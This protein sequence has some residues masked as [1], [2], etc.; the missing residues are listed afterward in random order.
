MDTFNGRT[1]RWLVAS[2][3]TVVVMVSLTA[4]APS[5]AQTQ[6]QAPTPTSTPVP[7]PAPTSSAAPL[8]PAPTP[9]ATARPSAGA[10][11]GDPSLAEMNAAHDHSMGSTIAANDPTP[12]SSGAR[13]FAA[14]SG[15]PPGIPGL[16]VSGWQVLTRSDWNTIAANGA[17]FAY[18]KATESTDYQS[19]QF[20][21]QYNDSYA[22]GLM[23]GAYHFA[24]PNTSSGA[25]QAN[26]F[27][28][29]G[30][31][32]SNDGRT[33]PPLL[34]IEYQPTG[35]VCWG[36]TAS[37][38]VSW[39]RDFSNTVLARVGRLPAIYS[40]TDWWTRCTGNNPGFGANPLFIARY[41][42]N[43][44]SGAGTL[45]AGW[46]NYTI[47]QYGSTGLF[48]G[49]QDTFN[50]TA[51][52][53]VA[54]ASNGPTVQPLT[55]PIIGVGDFNGDGRPDFIARRSDGSL[56]F[57]AGTGSATGTANPGYAPAV[58]IG[59]GW[60]I[61]NA[62]V[63]AGDLDGDG[64]PDLIAR[65]PDGTVYAY[66]G[67]GKAGISGNEGYNPA[68][69]IA[70]GWTAYTDL[71]AVGDFNGDG[72][73]DLLGRKSDGSLWLIPGTGQISNGGTF[74]TPTQIGSNWSIF[75]TLIGIGD[76]NKDGK[77]DLIGIGTDNTATFYAG[78]GTAGYYQPGQPIPISG[79]SSTDV[80]ASPGDLDGDGLPDILD[81]T[82]D[83]TLMLMS[84][85]GIRTPGYAPAQNAGGL[86]TQI[87]DMIVPGD[88]NGDGKPDAL[89]EAADG[90]LWLRSGTGTANPAFT[91]A[92]KIGWGWNIFSYLVSAGDING[93][94]KP[95]IL[96]VK[97]DGTLWFY[98]GTGAVSGTD[99]GYRPGIQIGWGWNVYTR[100]VGAGDLDGDGKSDLLAYKSDGSAYF[101]GGTGIVDATHQGYRPAVPLTSNLGA[102]SDLIAP[103][104][105]TGDSK[106]DLIV[107]RPDGGLW[108]YPGTGSV[109]PAGIAFGAPYRI[110]TNWSVFQRLISL[111]DADGDGKTDLMGVTASGTASFYKGTGN[112]GIL[113]PGFAAPIV[114][115]SNW[116]IYR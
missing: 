4:G 12:A 35:D 32:W 56:W 58:Q 75:R 89:T 10:V 50:G 39:I 93:D 87:S 115:G 101:Y 60:G 5:F 11:A 105:F 83:G 18:V 63:G 72:K 111:G 109:T 23:H 31:G 107:R 103:R 38:M 68:V 116:G 54:F 104:D 78:T 2:T 88:I 53:L 36:L 16:D 55:S 26:Y 99:S 29:N 13:S 100:I 7:S 108:L 96:G 69:Q 34:D 76:L 95:D 42:S 79:I 71:T 91:G 19:S 15:L 25:A 90:T 1:R 86:W 22:A 27:V 62:L 9:S 21:E 48:P 113:T 3:A 84:G 67:T 43:L 85:S 97:P 114:N 51:A 59:A 24:T 81:R 37:A 66:K 57:Y 112:A 40:T 74:G 106:A 33:L 92:T 41:P 94:G 6:T 82:L 73:P 14:V 80:F 77:P 46:T 47:W 17:K 98:A 102:V 49:D 28:D 64:I 30:G 110:G 65:K 70:S 61:Y 52:D 45:P 8:T 20:A 44:A